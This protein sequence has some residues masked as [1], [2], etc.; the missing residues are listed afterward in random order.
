MLVKAG[1]TSDYI[2]FLA[3]PLELRYTSGIIFD[4]L[5]SKTI[6][7]FRLDLKPY[8]H[9][10]WH[11]QLL[12]KPKIIKVKNL[13]CILTLES[14]NIVSTCS[15]FLSSTERKLNQLA[16]ATASKESRKVHIVQ[17]ILSKYLHYKERRFWLIVLVMR[18]IVEDLSSLSSSYNLQLYAYEEIPLLYHHVTTSVRVWRYNT[19]SICQ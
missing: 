9:N 3:L 8:V 12:L 14:I 2:V 1:S 19:Q 5:T 6:N 18:L 17:Q 7:R 4:K 15:T 13:R 10:F 11:K 16:F